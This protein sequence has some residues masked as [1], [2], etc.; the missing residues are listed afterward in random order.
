M[1]PEEK[2]YSF[3][4]SNLNTLLKA[5]DIARVL[6]ISR[7]MAY[8]LIQRGEIPS[9]RIGRVVRVRPRDLEEFI[10]LNMSLSH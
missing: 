4:E 7:S 6:N 9:V 10:M 1:K 3:S 8:Q 2:P 5:D